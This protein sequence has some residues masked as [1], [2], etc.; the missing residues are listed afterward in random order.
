MNARRKNPRLIGVVFGIEKSNFCCDGVGI[1]DFW[2]GFT[3]DR[4]VTGVW[5]NHNNHNFCNKKCKRRVPGLGIGGGL[6]RVLKM[7]LS[8]LGVDPWWGC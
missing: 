1:S 8:N 4:G 5:R 7:M 3:P 2:C 6:G